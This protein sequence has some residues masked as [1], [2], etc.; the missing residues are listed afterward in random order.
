[1]KTVFVLFVFSLCNI[2][3]VAIKYVCI[4]LNSTIN[5]RKYN[6]VDVDTIVINGS[7]CKCYFYTQ[8]GLK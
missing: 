1:M 6:I 8:K 2:G 4:P 3:C 5:T 7:I